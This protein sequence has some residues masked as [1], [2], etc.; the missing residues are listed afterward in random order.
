MPTKIASFGNLTLMSRAKFPKLAILD[1]VTSTEGDHAI[2][3]SERY[4]GHELSRPPRTGELAA[5]STSPGSVISA[6]P[7]ATAHASAPRP[8]TA[9]RNNR[10]QP[11]L[12]SYL[13][14]PKLV[15]PQHCNHR[16]RSRHWGTLG[17]LRVWVVADEAHSRVVVYEGVVDEPVDGAALGAQVTKVVPDR[18]QMRVSLV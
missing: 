5:Q 15:Y 18:Q 17:D 2:R 6:L 11:L 16:T 4:E 10:S 9:N 13:N 12:N 7:R 3:W 1:G 8:N 14:G